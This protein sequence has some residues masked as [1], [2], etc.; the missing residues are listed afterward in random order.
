MVVHKSIRHDEFVDKHPDNRVL[1][2]LS[3]Q[4]LPF[5]SVLSAAPP[6]FAYYMHTC[7]SALSFP[8]SK[9]AAEKNNKLTSNPFAG[10]RFGDQHQSQKHAPEI[11]QTSMYKI[12]KYV[13]LK[14]II[15]FETGF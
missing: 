14:S 5:H 9:V 1:R 10:V 13:F 12:V 2:S 6:L 3:T 7:N 8:L 11:G 15:P 4:T